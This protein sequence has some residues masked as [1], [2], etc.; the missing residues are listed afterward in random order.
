MHPSRLAR[1]FAAAL[2]AALLLPQAALAAEPSTPLPAIK[3]S[4]ALV[5]PNPLSAIAP[6]RAIVCKWRAPEGATVAKYRLWRTVD[7]GDRKLVVVKAPDA[8]LRHAD[9]N[10]RTG[11]TYRYLVTGVDTT[12]TRV[13]K[14]TVDKVYVVRP[15]QALR[16]N[17]IVEIDE[18]LTSVVCRWSDTTRASAVR[19]V[20]FRSVDG[21]AR[22][23]I[24]RVGEDGRRAFRDRDV[25]PGQAIRYAVVAVSASGRIVA[26]GGPDRVVI[27]N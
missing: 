19:Y 20:V 1:F 16:F 25:K 2:L 24:Y 14:S 9:Y 27:P 13:A 12:G 8:R 6:N 10:I 17:C 15:A 4:C 18:G 5:V 3:L 26:Y 11:H 23:A 22:Q 7:G 21:G